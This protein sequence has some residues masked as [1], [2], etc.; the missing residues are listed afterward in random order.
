MK[1][2]EVKDSN[3][4]ILE[5]IKNNKNNFFSKM[6]EEETIDWL[7]KLN[8]EK[9]VLNEILK[10]VKNG[11]DLI[12]LYNNTQLLEKLN[13]DLHNI[14]IIND[15]IEEALEEQL[16]INIEI[17]KDKNIVLNIENEPK[18]K[19]KEVIIYLEK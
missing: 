6:T 4:N 19:L 13:L 12:S 5:N 10:I 3:E 18:Y 9:N 2:D 1:E 8:L 16:K 15:A 17:E 7:N 11:K 14:N